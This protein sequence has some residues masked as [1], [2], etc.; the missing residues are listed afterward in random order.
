MLELVEVVV[1]LLEVERVVEVVEVD[2]VVDVVLVLRVVEVV[3]VLELVLVV[4]VEVLDVV[5]VVLVEVDVV[6]VEVEVVNAPLVTYSTKS[7]IVETSE[8]LTVPPSCETP[9][10]AASKS[11]AVQATVEAP[12]KS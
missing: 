10:W 8:P 7:H 5:L 2:R 6:V 9:I 4:V 12:G 11:A 1:V 3:L